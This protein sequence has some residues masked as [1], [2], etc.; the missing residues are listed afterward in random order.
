[1]KT[2]IRYLL[3]F[4]LLV[5]YSCDEDIE[6]TPK[7]NLLIFCDLSSSLSSESVEAESKK[8]QAIIK[9]IPFNTKISVYPMGLSI[10]QNPLLTDSI[11][12][13]TNSKLKNKV[14]DK[15]RKEIAR[16][17]DSII[18]NNYKTKNTEQETQFKS[19]IINSF[20]M[21]FNYLPDNDD[22]LLKN[23]RIIFL[24]DM[25]EQ[26]PES[27]AG[28]IYMC[29]K[30]RQPNFEEIKK[31]IQEEYNPTS[32][33]SDKIK[34]NQLFIVMTS[35]YGNQQKCLTEIQQN[36]IWDIV[37]QKQGFVEDYAKIIRKSTEVPST[38]ILWKQEENFND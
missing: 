22:K 16:V 31:Q 30:T 10:Y 34:T 1:M 29:S 27:S 28:S 12:S 17:L 20:E 2:I 3:V 24:T 7:K 14:I 4:L 38:E 36:E 18:I 25:I 37:L 23:S 8:I 35:N 32:K 15:K 5:I 11:K 19:C 21:A 26:C 33:L 9:N 13:E 6:T